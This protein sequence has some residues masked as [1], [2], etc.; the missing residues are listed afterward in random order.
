MPRGA[1]DT[2]SCAISTLPTASATSRTGG[3]PGKAGFLEE[4]RAYLTKRVE[5]EWVDV[6]RVHAGDVDGPYIMVVVA[7]TNF[8]Q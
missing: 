6:G 7:W 1:E 5:E 4:E 2:S 8:R 3:E